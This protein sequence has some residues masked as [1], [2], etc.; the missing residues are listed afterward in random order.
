MQDVCTLCGTP[1]G[2]ADVVRAGSLQPSDA[3]AVCRD[4]TYKP[5]PDSR[6]AVDA[7]AVSR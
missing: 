4:C 7:V 5:K 1:I 6:R 2:A 3:G